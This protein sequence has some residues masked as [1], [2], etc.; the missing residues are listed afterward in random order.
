MTALGL[1]LL[2]LLLIG[3]GA[4]LV[5]G[6]A[7]HLAFAGQDGAP[8]MR[9]VRHAALGIWAGAVLFIAGASLCVRGLA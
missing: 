8:A 9:T 3:T 1:L 5:M 6:A 7:V 4:V 2:A